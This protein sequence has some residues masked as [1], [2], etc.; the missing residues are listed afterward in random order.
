MK[1]THERFPETIAL[2]NRLR[3]KYWRTDR[4]PADLHKELQEFRYSDK[5]P[6]NDATIADIVNYCYYPRTEVDDLSTLRNGMK[7]GF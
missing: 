1:N 5:K 3:V 6:L 2:A 4:F 7:G